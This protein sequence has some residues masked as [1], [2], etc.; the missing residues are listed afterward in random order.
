MIDLLTLSS[1]DKWL[2]KKLQSSSMKS[3]IWVSWIIT[4]EGE[5]KHTLL[6]LHIA[7]ALQHL[8]QSS[9][10]SSLFY[11]SHFLRILHSFPLQ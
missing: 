10:C 5:G 6:L 11:R 2:S 1:V 9:H 3:A 4:C 8:N 7:L